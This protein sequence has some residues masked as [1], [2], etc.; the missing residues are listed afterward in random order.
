MPFALRQHVRQEGGDAVHD[1]HQIDV[2]DPAPRVER[3]GV[4]AAAAADAG[5]IAEDVDC[6]EGLQR[7]G[8]GALHAGCVRHVADDA[9]RRDAACAQVRDR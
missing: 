6:A 4:D 2:D 9:L 7:P 3:N 1:A 5:V 8:G